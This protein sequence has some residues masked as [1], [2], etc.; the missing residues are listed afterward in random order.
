M[1]QRRPPPPLHLL[2]TSSLLRGADGNG[3]PNSDISSRPLLA[4]PPQRLHH[5]RLHHRR[6][7]D[8]LCSRGQLCLN[9]LGV[10]CPNISSR[11]ASSSASSF[12]WISPLQGMKSMLDTPMESLNHSG[13]RQRKRKFISHESAVKSI[14]S[15]RDIQ[16]ALEIFNRVG[17]QDGFSHNH[18]TYSAIL[19]KL[20]RS[21]KFQAV[22]A[23][24]HQMTYETCKFHESIFLDLMKHF[25]KSL[26]HDR[27]LDMFDAIHTL[28]R[29]K[30]SL[31]AV[32]TCLNIL[33][34]SE[35]ID[36]ARTFLL[37]VKKSLKLMPNTCIF[38]ILVKH[39][40]RVG[41]LQSAYEVIEEMKKSS[42]SY[43]N[44]IT[45]ST[46][47]DG[48]CE[49][50]RLKEAIE[51]FEE[52]VSKD[53]IVPDALTYNILINGF[54]RSEKV[55]RARKILEF[56]KSNGCDPNLYNYSALM[57]GFCREGKVKEAEEVFEEMKS[58]GLK[59]DAVGYTTLIN[60]LCRGGRTSDALVLLQEMKE[61]ECKA[62]VITYNVL[63]R[64]F[65]E[66]GRSEDALAM[67]KKA[68]YEG[69]YLNKGSY[70]I[71]LNCLC[72]MGEIE[73]ATDLLQMMLD[74]G[75][76]PHYATSNELLVKLCE[77]GKSYK[78]EMTLAGLVGT[79]FKPEAESW[80]RL[81]E[82]ICRERKLMS[83]FELVDELT[84]W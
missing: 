17:E 41:D 53:Q 55:D 50:G 14:E 83:A 5:P 51:L 8:M 33:I 35:Q 60:C 72:K 82:L 27:V 34:E 29:E 38:N 67:L 59:P 61:M 45:Y 43:P 78:A 68:A 19:H 24:L 16:R 62:D 1:V 56:M 26:L 57:N 28:T 47:M 81:V 64:G 79:G 65:S 71:V 7:D 30:P 2:S 54:C 12:S 20:G 25:S 36:L 37:N 6:L 4:T 39:H 74:K 18:A 9:I 40:C 77:V 63:L 76:V 44:L 22:D 58:L 49:Q 66:E 10:I 46:V 42:T 3:T 48:L 21:K 84:G 75:Y 69:I 31:K 13:I 15:E 52:M 73:K 80:T 32:S 70:R 23:L 11:L